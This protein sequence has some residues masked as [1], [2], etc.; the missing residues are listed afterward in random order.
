MYVLFDWTSCFSK[1]QSPL[2]L[3][4]VLFAKWWFLFLFVFMFCFCFCQ[5]YH[6]MTLAEAGSPSKS[7]ISFHKSFLFLL[8]YGSSCFLKCIISN[9]VYCFNL[10]RLLWVW[11]VSK[12]VNFPSSFVSLIQGCSF[13]NYEN[14]QCFKIYRYMLSSLS[15]GE[16][17]ISENVGHWGCNSFLAKF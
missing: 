6:M 10:L 13:N 2:F 9:W 3:N 12:H 1:C 17:K 16:G 5:P 7:V 15:K 11:I 14:K 8:K 4:I